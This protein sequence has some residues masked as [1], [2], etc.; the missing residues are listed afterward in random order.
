MSDFRVG[1]EVLAPWANDG[2]FYPATLVRLQGTTAHVA[3]FDGAETDVPLAS[4]R[5]GVLGVGA[6][7]SVNWR[8]KGTYYRGGIAERIGPAL[9]LHYEDGTQG[10]ASIAQCRI[11]VEVLATIDVQF[12]ACGYCG[13]AMRATDINCP[14]C[15]APRPGR[16][17]DASQ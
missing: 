2:F 13:N 6:N 12:A 4:L 16:S 1:D 9:F 11:R 15:G 14:T 3:Y 7:V 10:W 5:R 8:G 17:P